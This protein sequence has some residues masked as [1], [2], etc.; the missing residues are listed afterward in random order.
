MKTTVALTGASGAMGSEALRQVLELPYTRAVVLLRRKPKNIRL[1]KKL[2]SRYGGRVEIIFGDIV[3]FSDCQKLIEK[4]D[5][6]VHC[7]A[8]IPPGSDKSPEECENINYLGTKNLVDA[9][10]ASPRRKTIKYV[11]ISTVA[12]YGNRNHRHPWGRVGDPLLVSAYDYY[13]ATKLRAERYVLEAGLEKFVSLR[14]T[15]MLHKRMYKNNLND[16]LMFHTAWNV[17]LEWVTDRDSGLLIK[18]LVK[19]DSEGILPKEFWNKCYN[20]GGG[21]CCRVTGYETFDASFKLM[22][23]SV[24]NFFKPYWNAARNFHGLWYSDSDILNEYLNFRTESC[25]D[26]WARMAKEYWYFRLGAIVPEKL[27]SK[28]VIQRLFKNPN[29]PLYWI[30]CGH[31]GRIKAFFGSREAAEELARDWKDFPVL[32]KGMCEDGAIDYC[33]LADIN[34]AKEF[35]LNHGYDESKPDGELELSDMQSAAAFRGGKCL[36]ESME[37]GD[38]FTKLEW[39]CHDGHRFF[40]APYTVVKAGHW[41][42]DCCQPAPWKFDRLAKHIPFFAQVWLD[43]HSPDEDA[44]YPISEDEDDV[45]FKKAGKK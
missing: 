11:H 18:N 17:P 42:P 37:K 23:A 33:A 35:K 4:A 27:L 9:V 41:C 28:L 38:L 8:L 13:A 20:I 30:N 7:A 40:A 45:L 44:V 36:S 16:G 10:L 26:F 39:E 6:L 32:K 43:T 24:E 34:G 19:F 31:E 14:Q 25:R 15:A 5:Y 1:A 29:A 22:G 3:S 2:S 21:G 12:L